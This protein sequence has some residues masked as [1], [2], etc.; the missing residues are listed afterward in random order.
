MKL[1]PSRLLNFFRFKSEIEKIDKS[2]L[3]IVI[4]KY[5]K[6]KHIEIL[7]WKYKEIHAGV[8]LRSKVYR[9]SGEARILSD[10]HSWSLILK[11][12]KPGKKDR[13][14]NDW[15]YYRREAEIYKTGWLNNLPGNMTAPRCFDVVDKPDG[16]VWLWLEDIQ[17]IFGSKWP[18]SHYAIA[19]R[20]LG[21][22]N[23]AY[24]SGDLAVPDVCSKTGL[25]RAGVSYANPIIARLHKSLSLPMSK[26]IVHR[27]VRQYWLTEDVSEMFFDL[28]LEQ[29][30]YLNALDQL[31]HTICHRD[32]SRRN[33]FA[34]YTTSSALKTVAI[35]WAL[36]GKSVIGEDSAILSMVSLFFFEVDL[37]KGLELDR[38][39]FENYLAGLR[40][41]GWRG[42]HRKIRL[43]HVASANM[44]ALSTAGAILTRLGNKNSNIGLEQA[45][46]YSTD[47]LADHFTRVAQFSSK[48][49]HEAREL[50][51]RLNFY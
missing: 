45:M 11:I 18:L 39:V 31:P 48:F 44:R 21:Q 9:F 1:K 7:T 4:G 20:H 43:G 22:F 41:S 14:P 35:D 33:L 26:F 51:R 34:Q 47:E 12:W 40:D 25:L 13:H 42:D 17:D 8:D 49:T 24:L 30:L 27:L 38:I 16:S 5:L 36:T 2:I 32:A 3:S 28:W 37:D 19:A 10:T 23:G 50:I 15:N 6:K 46:G 29:N